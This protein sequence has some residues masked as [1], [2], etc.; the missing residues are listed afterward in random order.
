LEE[1]STAPRRHSQDLVA[2]ARGAE[3][4]LELPGGSEVE[5]HER[6]VGKVMYPREQGEDRRGVAAALAALRRSWGV[7]RPGEVVLLPGGWV[8]REK[9]SVLVA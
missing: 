2:P 9:W 7:F 6:F 3:A 1:K 8:L 5:E 4:H